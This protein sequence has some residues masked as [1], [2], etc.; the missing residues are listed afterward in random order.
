MPGI[1]QH[2][3]LGRLIPAP[4][5]KPKKSKTKKLNNKQGTK[6]EHTAEGAGCSEHTGEGGRGKELIS[7]GTFNK[8]RLERQKG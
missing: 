2:S 4:S 3:P 1:N 5:K 7:T 8:Q 6:K